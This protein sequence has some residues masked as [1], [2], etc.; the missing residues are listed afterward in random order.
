MGDVVQLAPGNSCMSSVA[1]GAAC[2]TASCV[3]TSSGQVMD[4][5]LARR[6]RAALAKGWTA[7]GSSGVSIA[8]SNIHLFSSRE[9]HKPIQDSA[10]DCNSDCGRSRLERNSTFSHRATPAGQ[11][12]TPRTKRKGDREFPRH[13]RGR[14]TG[15]T[16]PP[17]DSS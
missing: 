1:R 15:R 2:S 13:L 3:Q 16:R 17:N 6:A 10:A 8:G 11:G 14:S 7:P 9:K 4:C 12:G 5:A